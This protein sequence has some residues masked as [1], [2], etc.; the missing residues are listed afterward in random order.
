MSSNRSK[1]A[2]GRA[3]IT[4]GGVALIGAAYQ[5]LLRRRVAVSGE[6]R[7]EAPSRSPEHELLDEMRIATTRAVT[8]DA[9]PEAIWPWLVQMGSNEDGVGTYDWIE[10]LLWLEVRGA[11]GTTRELS[12]QH[13]GDDRR[14]WPTA[15]DPGVQVE[16]LTPVGAMTSR[17]EDGT[18]VW[19]FL[20]V[21]QGASPRLERPVRATVNT[22]AEVVGWLRWRSE[23]A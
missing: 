20:L 7:D 11:D 16:I 23:H 19:T 4:A 12:G 13:D 3:L 2:I 14:A 6:T 15:N 9:P 10:Q 8:I 1:E 17:S 22:P 18:W 5:R 21:P